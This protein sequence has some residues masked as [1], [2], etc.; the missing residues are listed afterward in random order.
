MRYGKA[1]KENRVQ[2]CLDWGVEDA[3]VPVLPRLCRCVCV[4]VCG[5]GGVD[6][7]LTRGDM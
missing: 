1:R 4:C 5:G 7:M 6:V 2:S 3:G